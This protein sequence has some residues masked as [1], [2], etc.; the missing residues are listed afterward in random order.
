VPLPYT[1]ALVTPLT[2]PL[3]EYGM[4]GLRG[5][6]V[7]SRLQRLPEP[8]DEIALTAYDAH[9]DPVAAT[10]AALATDPHGLLGP[11]GSGPTAAVA[12]A[13][14]RLVWN[15]G[16]ATSRLVRR[17]YPRVV[18]VPAPAASYFR[19]VLDALRAAAPRAKAVS[20]LAGRSSFSREVAAGARGAARARG[21]EVRELEFARGQ[22]GPAARRVPPADV[23]LV[24]GAFD[25]EVAATTV[26]LDRPWLAAATVGAG[27]EE[28]LA[29]LGARREGLIGPAQWVPAASEPPQDGPDAATFV[30][31]Y[32]TSFGAEPPYPAAQAFAAGVL[33]ARCLREAGSA[34][35]GMLFTA[36]RSLDTT[37]MFG[38]FLLDPTTGLQVGHEVRV[39][40]WQDGVRRVVWPPAHA[41]AKLRYPRRP[42]P[43]T[44]AT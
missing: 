19:G 26:L 3:A 6:Q 41:E 42:T 43:A 35:E 15:H 1:L 24:V 21:F 31:A 36:A 14:D 33:L 37:T 5:A 30:A 4:A 27:T 40:Q 18:N 32:R 29:P 16:G 2:G 9:P 38:R 25:D 13:T 20:L 44:G 10:R 28:V 12:A 22:A 8:W 11:Y 34:D 7:W 17:T 39:V 23:L